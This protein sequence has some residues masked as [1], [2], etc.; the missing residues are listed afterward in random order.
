MSLDHLPRITGRLKVRQIKSGTADGFEVVRTGT[1]AT[2]EVA[3]T[4]GGSNRGCSESEQLEDL[5]GLSP[6]MLALLREAL[7]AW[8][9]QFD[10]PDKADDTDHYVFS[11]DLVEWFAD[12]RLRV[13]TA[14]TPASAS[15]AGIA[16]AQ[17]ADHG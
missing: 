6:V 13:R 12:W 4:H 5:L 9:E 14:L 8:V 1:S 2:G 10:A 16:I 17:E 15:P 7:E 11:A 3:P